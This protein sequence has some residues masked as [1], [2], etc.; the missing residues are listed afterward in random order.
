MPDPRNPAGLIWSHGWS[1]TRRGRWAA[2]LYLLAVAGGVLT[3]IALQL[4]EHVRKPYYVVAYRAVIEQLADQGDK[5]FVPQEIEFVYGFSQL[6]DAQQF[7]RL[8]DSSSGQGTG[9]SDAHGKTVAEPGVRPGSLPGSASAGSTVVVRPYPIL[10]ST[11]ARLSPIC[12]RPKVF[13]QFLDDRALGI[14]GEKPRPSRLDL[15]A[16]VSDQLA[17]RNSG[18]R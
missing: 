13:C 4:W 15:S 16:V 12:D 18:H 17:N 8:L 3:M 14:Q 7:E 1:R 9:D 6:A 10:L 2:R 5:P 11:A